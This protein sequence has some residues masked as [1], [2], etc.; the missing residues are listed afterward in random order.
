[1]VGNFHMP[2]MGYGPGS[3]PPEEDGSE[4]EYLQMPQNMRAYS[5][6][7]P[8]VEVTEALS[9]AMNL[10]KDIAD[11]AAHAAKTGDNVRFDL[12]KLD[13]PNRDLIAETMGEGEVSVKMHGVPAVAAQESVFAG[14]WVLKGAG[15]DAVEV[16]KMPEMA[17]ERAFQARQPAAGPLTPKKIGVLNAPSIAVELMDRSRNYKDGDEVHVINLSLLPHTE[18]DLVWLDEAMGK[19]S[20]DILSRGYGNCRVTATGQAHVWRVQFFNS[21]DT[22][23]LDTFEITDFPEVVIAADED[24]SDS[25]GRILEVLEA[26][27]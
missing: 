15:L 19:G 11:A 14:V 9:P 27:R 7:V 5:A 25:A 17:A 22:L 12:S 23:I 1:M 16:G 3:Q 10:L 2:P 13:K 21:M 18:E 8:Y 26:I 4:L 24:L 20:V 6:H